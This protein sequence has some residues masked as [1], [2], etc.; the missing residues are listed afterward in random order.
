MTVPKEEG[1][2][3]IFDGTSVFGVAPPV[4]DVSTFV[5]VRI[6]DYAFWISIFA[7]SARKCA[8]AAPEMLHMAP[9]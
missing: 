5:D 6:W 4:F 8:F 9:N 3:I 1:L 2:V 7:T